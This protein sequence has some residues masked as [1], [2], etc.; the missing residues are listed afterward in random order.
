MIAYLEGV[1]REKAPTR[2]VLDVA[3]VGYEVLVPL[4]TFTQLPD[5]GKTTSLRI[6]THVR[7]DIL[8]LFGFFSPQERDVFELLIRIS[9]VGPK[10]AQAIL[11]GISPEALVSAVEAKAVST[12]Q[13]VPGVGKKT[14]ERIV[15]ELADRVG[16]LGI[17]SGAPQGAGPPAS[18]RPEPA[19]QALSGLLNLGYPRSQAERVIDAAVE[20]L[21]EGVGLETLIRAALKGLSP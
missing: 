20:E 12:L 13:S 9:G 3:G 7:E 19:E 11:S 1:L 6:H 4:S 2:V 16:R 10:L 15:V 18:A 5:E 14:A 8:Q 17:G 21:G